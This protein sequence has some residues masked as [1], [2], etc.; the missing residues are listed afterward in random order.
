M[1][2]KKPVEN[3][4]EEIFERMRKKLGENLSDEDKEKYLKFGEKFHSLFNAMTTSS[5]S[6]DINMEESLSYVVESLKSGLHP[7]HLTEDEV[8]LVKAAYGDE[9]YKKLGYENLN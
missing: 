2:E 7:K 1:S 3:S 9:W 4:A 6:N 5:S 8:A